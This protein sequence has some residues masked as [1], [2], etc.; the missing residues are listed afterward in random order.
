MALRE[1]Q[2]EKVRMETKLQLSN[3][4]GQA[5][6]FDGD[7]QVGLIDF[8]FEGNIMSIIHTRTFPGHEGRGVAGIMMEAVNEYAIKHQLKVQ[9]ICSYAWAWY[10]KRPQFKDILDE[11]AGEGVSCQ[12]GK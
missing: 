6:A 12:I 11:H 1:K 9:P 5:L 2:K 4:A 8:T 3:E 7:E 10:Q